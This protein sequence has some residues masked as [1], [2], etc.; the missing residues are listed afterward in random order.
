MIRRPPRSTLFPYTSLFRSGTGE[1]RRDRQGTR[2][3]TPVEHCPAVELRPPAQRRRKQPRIAT[4]TEDTWQ[5]GDPHP[6]RRYP[7]T[8]EPTPT[9]ADL[10]AAFDAPEPLTVGLEEEL[11]LLH[12][13]TLDLLPRAADVAGRADDPRFKLEMPAAQL[14][15][16]L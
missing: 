16:S 3:G 11:M 9:A 14:E 6:R 15:L 10:R 12:P 8:A 1:R 2:A 13:G 5:P 7:M 4:G